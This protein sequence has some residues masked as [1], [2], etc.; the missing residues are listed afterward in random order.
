PIDYPLSLHDA[1]PILFDD[2]SRELSDED[3]GVVVMCAASPREKAGEK[4]HGYL[5]QSVLEALAG[6][7]A[8]SKKDESVYLHHVQQYIIDRVDR[9]STRLNSSHVAI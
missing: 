1:L 7:A 9:K 3:C 4:D 5:T 6:K 8:V 2:M